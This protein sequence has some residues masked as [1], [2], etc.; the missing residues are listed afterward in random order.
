MSKTLLLVVDVQE[1][2]VRGTLPGDNGLARVPEMVKRVQ[3]AV[4][5]GEEV[6][7]TQDTHFLDTY[8]STQEGKNLPVWHCVKDTQ[9][10][11]IIKELQQ[12]IDEDTV[13]VEKETFGSVPMMELVRDRLENQGYDEV[14]VL[15][16]CTDICVINTTA[17]L[18]NF[19]PEVKVSVN[20]KCSA[21]ITED[22][23][24]GALNTM[25]SFQVNIIR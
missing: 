15:G 20:A 8:E 4:D 6:M 12:F 9:G 18:K 17:L 11:E 25:E 5:K 23:H 13:I 2:F 16:I 21:G 3:E 22:L 10:W 7:F 1:D 24:N 14:E 19:F